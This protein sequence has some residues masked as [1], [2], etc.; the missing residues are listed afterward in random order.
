M[1]YLNQLI[2]RTE[3][4]I[5]DTDI[6]KKICSADTMINFVKLFLGDPTAAMDLTKDIGTVL[7]Q[8]PNEIF[9]SKM[10]M[11]LSDSY[12]QVDLE[13]RVKFAEK[14]SGDNE[15]FEVY[16][17]RQL[18]LINSINDD[19]KIYYLASLTRAFIYGKIDYNLYFKLAYIINQATIEELVYLSNNI[20]KPINWNMY[21]YS[22]KN[23]GIIEQT[24]IPQ[25]KDEEENA[26]YEYTPFAKA[27]DRFSLKF[28]I[29]DNGY[30]K[31]DIKVTLNNLMEIYPMTRMNSNQ[32]VMSKEQGRQLAE[33]V[34]KEFEAKI[35]SK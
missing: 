31:L 14:F 1:E 5:K 9:F 35:K 24:V 12:G 28:D 27:I 2:K 32:Y 10:K 13:D 18:L 11:F 20:N 7:Y 21:T 25:N 15:N 8:L 26:K 17:K 3:F 4:I 16:V 29:D 23:L 22:L 30:E 34:K 19:K 6:I 33:E